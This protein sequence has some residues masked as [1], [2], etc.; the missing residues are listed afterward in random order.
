M[1]K[2]QSNRATFS[3]YTS[4]DANADS[5]TFVLGTN[6]YLMKAMKIPDCRVIRFNS[7]DLKN[8]QVAI[9]RIDCNDFCCLV[10][11]IQVM[12]L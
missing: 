5:P 2:I 10:I 1:Y 8:S 11:G 4:G 12:G 9:I 3:R 7:M 6:V